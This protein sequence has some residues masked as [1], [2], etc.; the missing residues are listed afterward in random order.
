MEP[1]AGANACGPAG[2]GAVCGSGCQLRKWCGLMLRFQQ[3]WLAGLVAVSAAAWADTGDE[4]Y[5]VERSAPQYPAEAA[6]KGVEGEVRY[7]FT[8]LRNGEI[9]DVKI[10]ESTPPGVFDESA[11][12]AIKRWRVV[13]QCG[14]PFRKEFQASGVLEFRMQATSADVTP[15]Q[16]PLRLGRR[17][18]LEVRR[19][20]E[21]TVFG[22]S[23]PCSS[24]R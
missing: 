22:D 19:T 12:A 17:P 16:A 9:S 1:K 4:P 10:L 3:I 11:M 6:A 24:L 7:S 14:T 5:T 23:D 2:T 20:D 21:G 15:I 8:V 13:P 18:R